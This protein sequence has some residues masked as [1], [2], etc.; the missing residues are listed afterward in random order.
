MGDVECEIPKDC[1]RTA[2]P[3]PPPTP[4]LRPHWNYFGILLTGIKSEFGGGTTR[5][6][7]VNHGPFPNGMYC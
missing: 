3:A 5:T 4:T 7:N 1:F 2:W 6:C